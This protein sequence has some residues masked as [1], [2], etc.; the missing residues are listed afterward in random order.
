[1][2]VHS[3]PF[4]A[5][6][7]GI[8]SFPQSVD[9]GQGDK[10]RGKPEKFAEH[11][12]KATLFY[13]SQTAVEK[14][15]VAGGFRFELSKVTVP[16]IRERMVSALVNVSPELVATVAAGL[17]IDVPEAMPI[18]LAHLAKPEVT[19]SAALSLTGLPGVGGIRTRS[20]AILVAD[21]VDG[22][23]LAAV[24]A[25]LLAAGAKVHLIAPRLGPVKPT[26]GEPFDATG[27]LESSSSVLFD[28]IVLPDGA[29]GV[30]ALGAR[31][32]V[33]DFISN[34]YRHGKTL[35]AL[36]AS[37]ALI[38][39]AGVS[40]TLASGD[41]DPGILMEPAAKADHA[42]ANFI[43]ALG[44]HRHPEREANAPGP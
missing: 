22:K 26:S 42:A 3:C 35:L 18:V 34:Q 23:S 8:V 7:A 33:M 11:Y 40:P 30:K 24:Q 19:S 28:G 41:A 17:G 37:K 6:D 5:G 39:R 20:V 15:H 36:G 13:E 16:A 43:I 44:R 27:T 31:F 12:A 29:G 1:M 4:Q 10:L 2:V 38:E 21:G 32:E 14:S 9:Q 25:A